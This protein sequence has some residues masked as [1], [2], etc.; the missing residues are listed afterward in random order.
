MDKLK[1]YRHINRNKD[2]FINKY[3][4]HLGKWNGLRIRSIGKEYKKYEGQ[5]IK[6]AYIYVYL[7]SHKLISHYIEAGNIESYLVH[8]VI[9]NCSYV[10]IKDKDKYITDVKKPNNIEELKESDLLSRYSDHILLR[11]LSKKG[12]VIPSWMEVIDYQGKN[13]ILKDKSY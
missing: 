10:D 9:V 7:K 4:I 11:S 6:E 1:L 12:I 5:I 8:G 3:K 13:L 2:S